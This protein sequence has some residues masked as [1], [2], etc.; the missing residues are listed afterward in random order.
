M[1][2]DTIILRCVAF[3][4]GWFVMLAMGVVLMASIN[5]SAWFCLMMP[6]VGAFAVVAY[7]LNVVAWEEA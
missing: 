6:V 1:T 4:L 2:S 5:A 3:V 7:Q